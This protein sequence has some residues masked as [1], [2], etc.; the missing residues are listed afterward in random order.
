MLCYFGLD[1]HY[2]DDLRSCI[3][4]PADQSHLGPP[5]PVGQKAIV[6]NA[7]KAV[8]QDVQEEAAKEF[9]VGEGRGGLAGLGTRRLLIWA[10]I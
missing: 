9:V 1:G 7:L 3:E 10:P 5:M 2:N 4:Q 8:G 6:P